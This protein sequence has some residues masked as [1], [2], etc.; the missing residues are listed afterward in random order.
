MCFLNL[1][2]VNL[3]KLNNLV[4]YANNVKIFDI[5]KKKNRLKVIKLLNF[6]SLKIQ[7]LVHSK[8]ANRPLNKSHGSTTVKKN[9]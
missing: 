3:I 1:H 5:Y 8:G 7:F 6:R 9:H 2:F 4:Y